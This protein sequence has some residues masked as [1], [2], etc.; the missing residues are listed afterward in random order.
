MIEP[1]VNTV[2][3]TFRYTVDIHFRIVMYRY[4]YKINIAKSSFKIR[5][6]VEKHDLSH[7]GKI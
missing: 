3:F 6:N 4:Y 7:I 5:Y 2:A 1:L